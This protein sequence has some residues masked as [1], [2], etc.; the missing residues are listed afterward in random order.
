MNICFLGR[1][2]SGSDPHTRGTEC[3]G[4]RHG[5]VI[6]DAACRENR[7]GSHSINDLWHKTQSSKFAAH[8]AARVS[9]LGDDEIKAG[10]GRP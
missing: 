8:V 3:E 2:E 1:Q 7:D 10:L 9:A 4:C 6:G 5:A